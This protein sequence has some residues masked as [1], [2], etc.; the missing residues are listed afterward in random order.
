MYVLQ[1]LL[2]TTLMHRLSAELHE[3][4]NHVALIQKFL[5][6]G[7]PLEIGRFPVGTNYTSQEIPQGLLF[8][9][10]L[11]EDRGN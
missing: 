5:A 11:F 8:G 4:A 1:Q 6:A 2:G 9:P 10:F 7:R 3:I